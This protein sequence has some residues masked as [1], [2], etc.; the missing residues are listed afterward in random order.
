MKRFRMIHLLLVASLLLAACAQP[1]PEP[2]SY[3]VEM[4]EFVFTPNIIQAKVG[5]PVVLELINKGALEHEIMIGRDV[6]MMNN[7]P[8]GYQIDMFQM[9]GVEP[10]VLIPDEMSGMGHSSGAADH[11]GFMVV[12]PK[13]GDR[14]TL[15]FT[16]TEDMIGEWEIGCFSQEGVH[17]DAGMKG[18]LIIQP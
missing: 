15:T 8:E 14:A 9:A 6:M 17:Y 13:S 7:R 4:S 12:L 1:T 2:V 18:K 3:P 16:P 5:Q 11:S 10:Q